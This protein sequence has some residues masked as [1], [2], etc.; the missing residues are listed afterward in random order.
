M[1]LRLRL[2]ACGLAVLLA[3]CATPVSFA[4]RER[5][6]THRQLAEIKLGRHEVELSIRQYKKS[7]EIHDKDPEAHFG[8]SEAYRR[9]GVL[10]L[11]EHHLLETLR[12]DPE[13]VDARLNLGVVYLQLERWQD[14]IRVNSALM[15]DPTF[16]RPARALVNR[17]W[18]HYKSGNA[19]LAQRD[20]SEALKQGGAGLYAHMNLGILYYGRGETVDAVTQFEQVLEILE[21]RPPQV[22]GASEAEA[23]FRLAQ[24]H[25]R[26][27]HHAEA[28]EHLRV[29][30]ER[31]GKG[32]WGR[33]SREYLAVLR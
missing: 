32:K 31:G 21:G 8:I 29:V 25:V 24:A 22:F 27:G 14:A 3:G 12:L 1:S 33:K 26:L 11:A 28:I 10:D 15:E 17:G 7:L 18:A 2:L 13:N 5:A 9:K 16:F 19:E 4:V 20:Y 6:E 30:E 23:R